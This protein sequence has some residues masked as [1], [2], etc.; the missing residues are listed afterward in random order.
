M[1][2]GQLAKAT[3]E[4]HETLRYWTKEDLLE[5]AD[6]TEAGYQL[7]APEMVDQVARIRELQSQRFTIKEIKAKFA[8]E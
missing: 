1:R 5:V 7:Y 2:I 3:R 8:A 4:S 6:A